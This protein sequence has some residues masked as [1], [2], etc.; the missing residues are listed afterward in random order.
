MGLFWEEFLKIVGRR[1]LVI[2]MTA[3]AVLYVL[4]FWIS[5]VGS[6]YTEVDGV[7]YSGLEAVR[8]DREIAMDWE[9]PLT[10]E[11]LRQILEVYGPAT[12]E[13]PG[14]RS[15]R[16]G[17]WVS[18]YATDMLTDYRRRADGQAELLDAE[19]LLRVEE[20]TLK[21]QPY[22]TY[23]GA[24][25]MLLE[26][27]L[28]GNIGLLLLIILGTA[29][30]FAEE[31]SLKTAELIR[32][33]AGGKEKDLG[34][35][36]A[37]SCIFSELLFILVNAVMLCSFLTVYGMQVLRADACLSGFTVGFEKMNFG[38]AWLYRLAWGMLA[39]LMMTAI[40]LAFSA[41]C[42]GAFP[43][44]IA[45]VVCMFAGL[46]LKGP[47]RMYMPF[48]ILKL[49]CA[50]LGTWS[51]VILINL[52]GYGTNSREMPWRLFY[53]LIVTGACLLAAGHSWR[54]SH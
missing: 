45:S 37:A 38:Q 3:V 4:W 43:A 32:T 7:R 9:G 54:K 21:D 47:V 16:K 42:Q 29:P 35:R 10:M 17:N 36:I 22:F 53:V 5:T 40:S 33:S 20:G 44:L 52:G 34:M 13:V 19:S 24:A 12:N 39:A 18:R 2:W 27:E 23:M 14:D 1:T 41:K 6:E 50:V 48:R 25:D 51:P 30:V 15:T 26:I 49:V 28:F 46:L 31:Y 11:K 8:R